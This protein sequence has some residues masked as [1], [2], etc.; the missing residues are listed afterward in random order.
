MGAYFRYSCS[1]RLLQLFTRTC[2]HNAKYVE[3]KCQLDAIDYFYCRS[4]CL[5]NMFRAPLCPSSGAREYYTE[6][7]CLWYLVLWFS[8]CRYGVELRV[9]CP[10]CG[11]LPYS[12]TSACHGTSLLFTGLLC[13]VICKLFVFVSVTVS[14]AGPTC[15]RN[16]HRHTVTYTR[17]CI[18]TIDSLDD[19]HGVAR[20]M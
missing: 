11:L 1:I 14:C 13:V 20:N 12:A 9:M 15:S 8:S 4:Y 19:E 10:V 3:I 7:S 17:C 18:D 16:C 6:D 2:K 5:L